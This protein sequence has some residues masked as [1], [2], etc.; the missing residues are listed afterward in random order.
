MDYHINMGMGNTAEL[1]GAKYKITREE[2]D[3][4]AFKS[5]QRWKLG[6]KIY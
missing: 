6:K 1:L 2:C 5:Q 4:Y 3:E